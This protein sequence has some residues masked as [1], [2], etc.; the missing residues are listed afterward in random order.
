[1]NIYIKSPNEIINVLGGIQKRTNTKKVRYSKLCVIVDVDGGKVIYN[2]LTKS[3]VFLTDHDFEVVTKK[4]NEASEGFKYL[5]G[6]YFLVTEN[7]NEFEAAKKVK[8]YYLST[9]KDDIRTSKITTYTIL[10]TTDCN[11][12]CFYCYER[13]IR[14]IDMT[15]ETALKIVK[16]IIERHDPARNVFLR[17]F[18]GE[19]LYNLKIID[20]ICSELRKAK[21]NFSSNIVTNGY[22]LEP[23]VTKRAADDWGLNH[24]QITLDGTE[25]VYNKA[26]NYIYKNPDV[27]PFTHVL[28]NCEEC[29]NNNIKVSFRLNVDEYNVEDLKVLLEI[30]YDRFE[31]KIGVSVF[32]LFESAMKK[33][34]TDEERDKLY[35]KIY[36]LEDKA[37]AMGL[38]MEWPH[39][40]Y[41]SSM[42]IVDDGRSIL[43]Q[44]DGSMGLCE[45]HADSNK[46]AHIDNPI[47]KEEDIKVWLEKCEPEK[48]LCED[49]PI[50]PSCVRVKNCEEES[51]CNKNV[52]ERKIIKEKMGIINLFKEQVRRSQQQQQPRAVINALEI[53]ENGVYTPTDGVNG[54]S[55]VI[56]N[57][58]D[59]SPYLPVFVAI[60][61]KDKL[62]I[63]YLQENLTYFPEFT[64]EEFVSFINNNTNLKDNDIVVD[65][66]EKICES[67]TMWFEI[68]MIKHPKLRSTNTFEWDGGSFCNECINLTEGKT[69]II[70]W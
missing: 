60:K 22:L 31:T 63:S 34:R 41:K 50:F 36:E 42:C 62:C 23:S 15:E 4:E 38:L 40:S 48:G 6:N 33:K 65:D 66:V 17:W 10:P 68:D 67:K 57:V 51:V 3:L 8:N 46:M 18:G 7:F 13:N 19:P 64:K 43:F 11:A 27:S 49:C 69:K 2:E 54:F 5:F 35:Q 52:K 70:R 20:L 24:V 53:T 56:V 25:K 61:S 26:K 55:P 47:F 21:I 29:L 59:K 14:H 30:I 32:P 28:D 12:R 1:M 58:V 37:R 44:P 9:M 16:F 39:T 45:H